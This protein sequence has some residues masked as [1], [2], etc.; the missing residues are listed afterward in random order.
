MK[1]IFIVLSAIL[2]PAISLAEEK[3]VNGLIDNLS[4]ILGNL[5]LLI[6]SAIGIAF[7]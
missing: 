3:G 2:M 4:G 6:L 5:Y 1:K 7:A